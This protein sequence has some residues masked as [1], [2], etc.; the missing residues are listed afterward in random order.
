MIGVE[1]SRRLGRIWSQP[2]MDVIG[3]KNKGVLRIIAEQKETFENL[4]EDLQRTIIQIE[5][6]IRNRN[7]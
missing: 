1:L 4:P 7:K 6:A 3:D 5:N 2:E